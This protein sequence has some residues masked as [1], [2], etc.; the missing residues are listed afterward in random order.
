MSGPDA[1]GL[2]TS[3][4]GIRH[5]RSRRHPAFAPALP[6]SAL[7]RRLR[8]PLPCAFA[9]PR[10]RSFTDPL[11]CVSGLRLLRFIRSSARFLACPVPP[12]RSRLKRSG[13]RLA[14]AS[15]MPS[16][17]GRVD[18][19]HRHPWDQNP[20][21]FK[22]LRLSVPV[23]PC[24]EDKLKVRLNRRSDNI[25][26]GDFSTSGDLPCGHEWIT[27]RLVAFVAKRSAWRER[28]RLQTVTLQ[29]PSRCGQRSDSLFNT[30]KTANQA[31]RLRRESRRRRR[32]LSLM[33]PSA[34]FWS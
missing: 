9:W 33:K 22:A 29:R 11:C 30:R 14:E 16:L 5:R 12:R 2:A 24:P 8:F 15:L 28:N 3:R 21:N 23:A 25:R 26:T 7:A 32:P 13:L 19:C 1:F 20:G 17:E 18:R 34:S 6:R 10:P 27:Q 31:S 4:S